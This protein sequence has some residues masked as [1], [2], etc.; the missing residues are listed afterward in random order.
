MQNI[1]VLQP[2]VADLTICQTDKIKMCKSVLIKLFLVRVKRSLRLNDSQELLTGETLDTL[3]LIKIN[4]QKNLHAVRVR[5]C[6][7]SDHIYWPVS[8]I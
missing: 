2:L 5:A 3:A 7:T 1:F 4:F 6:I 8:N